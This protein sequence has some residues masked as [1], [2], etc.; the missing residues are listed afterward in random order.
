MYILCIYVYIICIC[1]YF[2]IHMHIIVYNCIYPYT[3]PRD[4]RRHRG[5]S[6]P[7]LPASEAA[8]RGVSQVVPGD[9]QNSWEMDGNGCPFPIQ[10]HM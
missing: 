10:I 4:T 7:S 9:H 5:K 6:Q 8:A 3:S 2:C 1:I